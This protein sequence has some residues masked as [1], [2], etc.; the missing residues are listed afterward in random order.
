MKLFITLALSLVLAAGCL[1]AGR[2]GL[3]SYT[4][5]SFP[6]TSVPAV[7][8]DVVERL[9]VSYPPGRTALFLTGSDAFAQALENALRRRGY[10]V[11]PEA[12]AGAL[13]LTW[14]LNRLG[15]GSW[16]LIVML[17]DGYS[18]SRVYWGRDDSGPTAQIKRRAHGNESH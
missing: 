15:D 3:K 9:Y 12:Y 2:G 11:S 14:T 4:A 5:E 18:F 10:T 16:Y 1:G 7:V 8:E 13:S 17:S 6:A